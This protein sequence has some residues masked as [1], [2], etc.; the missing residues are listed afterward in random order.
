M[1]TRSGVNWGR[2]ALI[3]A[4]LAAVVAIAITASRSLRQESA[5]KAAVADPA[6]TPDQAITQL[7]AKL[8]A[9]PRNLEGWQMLGWAFFQTGRY[10]EA[11]T[12]YRRATTLAPNNAT[13]WS[14]LGEAIVHTAAEP[15]MPPAASEAFAKAL[16]IDAKDPRA[17]YW[18]AAAKDL[19]GDPAGA[20]DGWLALLAD[21]P[22]GAP[23]EQGLRET[24]AAVG[25]RKNIAVD[26][27]LA[28]VKQAAPVGQAGAAIPGPSREQMA[29][30]AKLPPGQQQAMVTGMV[31]GLET[32]LK[33]NPA[34]PDGWIMLMR[35]RMTLGEANK[36]SAAY[37]DG[38]AANPAA[39]DQ[40]A[41]AAKELGVPGA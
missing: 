31:E 12:A 33:A 4:A 28:A 6:S 14:S 34:N 21:T 1:A 37:R 2:W 40:L 15:V 23:W 7:E 3:A 16:A 35:S 8:K 41:A 38:L 17:R 10:A 19:G 11:A 20:I 5:P 9:D 25:K 18:A 26:Q 22:N 39:R 36:A 13:M 24:I 27:R 30:A 32:K 29:L